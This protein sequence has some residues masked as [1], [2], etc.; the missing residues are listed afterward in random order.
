MRELPVEV[1]LSSGY[2][3]F[4]LAVAAVLEKLAKHSRFR[5]DQY[6]LAGFRYRHGFDRWEC[7]EGNHLVRVETDHERRIVRY[8]APAHHCNACR[9]KTDCTDSEI[10]REIE[11]QLDLW[12]RTGLSQF[13]RGLSLALVVL[14]ALLLIVEALRYP[15]AHAVTL[16]GALLIVAALFGLSLIS[17]L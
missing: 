16:L 15:E 3:I 4:L 17:P 2:A 13:H 8:R 9:R 11:R 5:A 14:A 12:L 10:G 6:E 7:P 1:V